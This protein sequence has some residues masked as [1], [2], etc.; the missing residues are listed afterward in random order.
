MSL[1]MLRD[2]SP[3]PEACP[4]VAEDL[5]GWLQT[6]TAALLLETLPDLDL[7]D[8]PLK[9][10]PPIV[11]LE[12]GAYKGL[13]T[14]LL[15][16]YAHSVITVDT[17]EGSPEHK[18]AG[19]DMDQVFQIFLRNLWYRK[20]DVTFLRMP[21]LAGMAT[22]DRYGIK[23]CTVYLDADHNFPAVLDDLI[24]ALYLFPEA[25]IVGDDW[26]W[27]GEDPRYPYPVQMA[28]AECIKSGVFSRRT[29]KHNESAFQFS[30]VED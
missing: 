22:V 25:Y 30:P 17:W 24:M 23:P 10:T 15:V 27:R 14:N 7:L 13:A 12:I 2:L 29:W 9:D 8:E 11:V 18:G 3:W 5:S 19:T 6:E 26:N 4:R 28:V 21:S 20:E 1:E 16:N